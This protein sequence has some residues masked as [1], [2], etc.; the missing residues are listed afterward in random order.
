VFVERERRRDVY[1]LYYFNDFS[2]AS[3][4]VYLYDDIRLRL[5]Y[6]TSQ[7]TK[8]CRQNV[9]CRQSYNMGNR[10]KVV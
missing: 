6:Y 2:Y 7:V 8:L 5:G 1:R 4:G 9:W 10:V 3:T